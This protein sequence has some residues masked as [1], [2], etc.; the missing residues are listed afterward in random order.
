MADSSNEQ[1]ESV[2]PLTKGSILGGY[3]GQLA[4][5]IESE[6]NP[7][8][9]AIWFFKQLKEPYFMGTLR[10]ISEME[11]LGR[12]MDSALNEFAGRD[13]GLVKL[14]TVEHLV[15]SMKLYVISRHTLLDLLAYLV[16]AVFNLGI[17]DRDVKIQLVLNNRHVQSS[18]IPQI[19]REYENSSVIKGL[20]KK[21]NDLVHRG[22]IPDTDIEQILGE[23][24]T[25]DSRRYSILQMDQISEEEYKKQ[26]SILQEKLSVLAKEKQELWREHH[27][28]TITMLSEIGG[29]LA[30][31]TIE[32]YKQR[33]T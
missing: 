23:R 30:L 9:A 17:A 21:R 31:K 12:E 14:L 5:I 29:E 33:A 18:R 3:L 10:I 24:N 22:K 27:Q 20:K 15:V 16:N 8:Q 13:L 11:R 25:I 7:S 2:D 32:S 4:E 19:I 28:Q 6:E 1:N 26:S